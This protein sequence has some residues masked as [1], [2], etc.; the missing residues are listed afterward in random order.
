MFVDLIIILIKTPLKKECMVFVSF[1]V[2][3]CIL[4]YMVIF[5]PMPYQEKR[6]LGNCQVF[7]SMLSFSNHDV[8]DVN[9]FMHTIKAL[10]QLS[11]SSPQRCIVHAYGTRSLIH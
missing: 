3:Q 8:N 10:K 11:N 1:N 9:I 6:K 4:V 2:V 7:L 5:P